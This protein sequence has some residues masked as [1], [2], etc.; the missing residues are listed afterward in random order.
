MPGLNVLSVHRDA[1]DL[2]PARSWPG[3]Y[4]LVYLAKDG[5]VLCAKCATAEVDRWSDADER[6]PQILGASDDNWYDGPMWVDVLYEGRERC[7]NCDDV[8]V[9]AYEDA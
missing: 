1:N 9:G 4:T 8:I 7:G 6:G 2:L 5:E 3:L